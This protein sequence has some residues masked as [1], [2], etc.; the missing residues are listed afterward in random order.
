ML[1]TQDADQKWLSPHV[2]KIR[3]VNIPVDYNN[4]SLVH[5]DCIVQDEVQIAGSYVLGTKAQFYL[6]HLW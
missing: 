1:A 4:W 3:L 6:L 2:W 5:T